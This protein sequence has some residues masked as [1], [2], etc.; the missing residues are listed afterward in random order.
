MEFNKKEAERNK[1]FENK[2]VTSNYF[3]T[4]EATGEEEDS[5]DALEEETD[6][7]DDEGENHDILYAE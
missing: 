3:K 2:K 7:E 6:E 4:E 5:P 1:Q